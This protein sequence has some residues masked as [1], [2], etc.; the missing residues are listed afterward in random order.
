MSLLSFQEAGI[1]ALSV[2][3]VG[4][5]SLGEPIILSKYPQELNDEKVQDRLLKFFL[6]NFKDRLTFCFSSPG[7]NPLAKICVDIFK[8]PHMLHEK[9]LEIAR[10]LHEVSTHHWIKN[11][12]CWVVYFKNVEYQGEITDAFGIFKT[13]L[14]EEFLTV[15][16]KDQGFQISLHEGFNI[17]KIDKGCLIFNRFQ[18]KG[19]D[20]MIIDNINIQDPAEY[21]TDKFLQV[22]PVKS[23]Y[24]NT[25]NEF[26]VLKAFLDDSESAMD[27]LDKVDR[28]NNSVNYM[29]EN[30]KFNI[31][32]FE[33]NLFP[34]KEIR[35]SFDRFR[36]Q[37]RDEYDV[38][39]EDEY[40]IEQQVIKNPKKFIRSVI[41]L[42]RDFHIY[43]HGNRANITRGFDE[44]KGMHFY[45]IFFSEE[46]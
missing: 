10:Q 31:D 35:N 14:K 38:E 5:R 2:H 36:K 30:E 46:S 29:K 1:E 28:L 19:Y 17:K 20:I 4:N 23:S 15:R 26:K 43:V 45:K 7:T 40:D 18:E 21:W 11:G 9:S 16:R 42:D 22:K 3:W 34:E 39:I 33:A 44:E 41:K 13:E 25:N 32:D 24:Y 12:E 37:Y 8:D 27:S 6:N